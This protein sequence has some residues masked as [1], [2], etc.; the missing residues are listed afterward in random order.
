MDVRERNVF[1]N[2][3]VATPGEHQKFVRELILSGHNNVV[4]QTYTGKWSDCRK[5]GKSVMY[6]TGEARHPTCK[7]HQR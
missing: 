2:A 7:A 4:L 3:S 6:N 5:H 1:G